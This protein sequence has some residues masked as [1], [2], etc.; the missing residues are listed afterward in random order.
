MISDAHPEPSQPSEGDP[1]PSFENRWVRLQPLSPLLRGGITFL[2]ILGVFLTYLRDRV[3]DIF[4]GGP[5]E[6]WQG[7]ER[8]ENRVV[9]MLLVG[10]LVVAVLVGV[11]SW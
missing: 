3:V 2:V 9:V 8:F 11:F 5:D 1:S 7:V 4:F 6:G 10:A